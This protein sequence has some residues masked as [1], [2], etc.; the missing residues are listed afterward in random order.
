[1]VRRPPGSTRT[2]T[3]FPYTTLCRSSGFVFRQNHLANGGDPVRIEEHV[4]RAAK[5]DPFG[6]E[7]AR[8]SRIQRRLR[9]GAHLEAADLVGPDH[10]RSEIARPF[11]L[12]RRP[13]PHHPFPAGAD[14]GD[15]GPFPHPP[16]GHAPPAP[17][18]SADRRGG[19]EGYITN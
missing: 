13:P 15:G 14:D 6:P 16:A 10:Q 7:I 11:G 17:P 2:D 5:A 9:I 19:K 8:G 18:R 3:L 1:M 4:F 12:T